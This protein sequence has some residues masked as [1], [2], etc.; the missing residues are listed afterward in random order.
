M[1]L[2]KILKEVED[3]A[4]IDALTQAMGAAFQSIGTEFQNKEA[5]IKKDVEQS[6]IQIKE[7]LDPVSIVGILLALPKLV[8]VLAK[9]LGKL[10]SVFKK[11]IK[12]GE[13]KGN[14]EGVAAK[15]IEFTHKWHK[16]YIKGLKW[17][18]KMSGAFDKAG[19]EEEATQM[20]VAEMVYYIIVAGLAVYS[21]IQAAGAFKTAIQTA[22]TK[23]LEGAA[24]GFSTASMESALA[25]VKSGEVRDFIAK[26]GLKAA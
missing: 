1:K 26:L 8:E 9:G 13:A 25:A 18:L 11:F 15:I 6:D 23:G 14:E 22:T 20:K 21:G 12:P 16:T 4:E 7:I 3:K 2:Q 17:M 24:S 10:V 19:I 5:E